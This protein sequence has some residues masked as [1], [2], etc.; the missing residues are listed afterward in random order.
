MVLLIANSQ[1]CVDIRCGTCYVPHM[2]YDRHL[3]VEAPVSDQE[4]DKLIADLQRRI[5]VLER[6]RMPVGPGLKIEGFDGIKALDAAIQRRELGPFLDHVAM[7]MS[8]A[9]WAFFILL[10]IAPM[11]V[12]VVGAVLRD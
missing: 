1:E 5:D 3:R 6:D 7:P 9:R 8:T 11:L 10:V 12:V 2:F 4:K